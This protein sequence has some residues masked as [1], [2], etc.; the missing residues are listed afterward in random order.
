MTESFGDCS[1]GAIVSQDTPSP[2]RAAGEGVA[3][4]CQGCESPRFRLTFTKQPRISGCGVS[5]LAP[6]SVRA[7]RL[8]RRTPGARHSRNRRD[9]TGLSPPAPYVPNS[10]P[11]VT[12]VERCTA[13]V[14]HANLAVQSPVRTGFQ[15][16]KLCCKWGWSCGLAVLPPTEPHFRIPKP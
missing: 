2:N 13:P 6:R 16:C 4:G 8:I 12:R 14:W 9:R 1:S 7:T 3:G 11:R 10:I 5:A 15:H